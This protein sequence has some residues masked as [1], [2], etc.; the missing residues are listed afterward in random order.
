MKHVYAATFM[1]CALGII[2]MPVST[3]HAWHAAQGWI[4]EPQF[5]M[6]VAMFAFMLVGGA[7]LSAWELTEEAS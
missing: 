7:A 5:R 4:S 6:A 2:A 1:L 3:P